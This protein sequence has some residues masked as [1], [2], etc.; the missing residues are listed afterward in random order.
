VEEKTPDERAHC[1][2]LYRVIISA[3]HREGIGSIGRRDLCG[4]ASSSGRISRPAECRICATAFR[5][6]LPSVSQSTDL[7]VHP[8]PA[9]RRQPFLREEA[10]LVVHL[11]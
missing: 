3:M 5:E 2:T 1:P 11:A 6:P 10:P 4:A 7:L 8:R 9:L